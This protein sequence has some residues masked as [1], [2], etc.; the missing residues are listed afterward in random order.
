MYYQTIHRSKKSQGIRK[1]FEQNDD[2]NAT[3][4]NLWDTAKAM[5]KERFIALK[6]YFRKQ[7][8]KSVKYKIQVEQI[9]TVKNQLFEE[10]KQKG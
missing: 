5:L 4:Q 3:Y 7:D 1:Y 10:M 6:A 2:E 8:K 9:N